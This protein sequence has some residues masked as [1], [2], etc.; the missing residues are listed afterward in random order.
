MIP[1]LAGP[2]K[3][4]ASTAGRDRKDGFQ[5]RQDGSPR[6][7]ALQGSPRHRVPVVKEQKGQGRDGAETVRR[8]WPGGR[9]GRQAA[10][11]E[12]G[13]AGRDQAEL[14]AG[15]RANQ[16]RPPPPGGWDALDVRSH[17]RRR[18]RRGRDGGRIRQA[19]FGL[20]AGTRR[21]QR[22]ER[23][24]RRADGRSRPAR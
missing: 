14:D 15:A 7:Q 12:A 17:G 13:A 18:P 6:R 8:V 1:R 24:A 5:R 4:F 22:S 16:A 10:I 23:P 9:Q 11:G 2:S 3:T 21:R 20:A 19:W